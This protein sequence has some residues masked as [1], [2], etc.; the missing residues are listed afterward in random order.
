MAVRRVAIL[1]FCAWGYLL[2]YFLINRGGF[3]RLVANN[4]IYPIGNISFRIIPAGVIF[5][6]PLASILI[7]GFTPPAK[8][9]L[10][11]RFFKQQSPGCKIPLL[12]LIW[13]GV[14]NCSD[15]RSQFNP[16]KS[17][18]FAELLRL[19]IMEYYANPGLRKANIIDTR[20]H[21]WAKNKAGWTIV[22]FNPPYF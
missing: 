3:F 16:T 5:L 12:L 6:L 2:L 17:E 19:S 14:F 21:T 22:W 18:T 1:C 8:R 15:Q 10:Q 13:K 20:Q 9:S 7:D 11:H 4:C